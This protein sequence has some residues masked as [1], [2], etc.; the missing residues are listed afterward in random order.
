MFKFW[1]LY[2]NPLSF[3]RSILHKISRASAGG[4]GERLIFEEAN[5]Q[6]TEIQQEKLT[7]EKLIT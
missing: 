4:G 2:S 6:K 7:K 5:D 1:T 3:F